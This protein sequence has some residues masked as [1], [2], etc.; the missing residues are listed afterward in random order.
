[1]SLKAVAERTSIVDLRAPLACNNKRP[2]FRLTGRA[3]F[4]DLRH[5]PC[6]VGASHNRIA[7]AGT[8]LRTLRRKSV[9]RYVISI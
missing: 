5:G 9:T 7:S 6:F 1:M 2:A 8:L 3:F 4:G